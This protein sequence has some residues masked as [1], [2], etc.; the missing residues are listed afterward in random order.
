[1]VSLIR[2]DNGVRGMMTVGFDHGLSRHLNFTLRSRVEILYVINI[3]Q[4]I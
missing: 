3:G 2:F 1:M 4:T